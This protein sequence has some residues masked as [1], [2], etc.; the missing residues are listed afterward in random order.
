[1]T[2]EEEWLHAWPYAL[3]A[4]SPFTKLAPPRLCLTAEDE[5][6]EGLTGSFAMIRL[7]DHA[8]VVGLRQVAARGL[9]DYATEILAHEVGHHVYAPADLRD[10]ARLM[11]RVRAGLPSRERDAALVANLY[12]D[13]LINDRLQR[14]A[15][16]DMIGVYRTLKAPSDDPLWQV[17]LRMYEV[18]WSLPSGSL[19]EADLTR[20]QQVDAALGARLVRTHARDWV[21]GA[22]SFAVLCLTYLLERPEGT[23]KVFAPWLDAAGAGAGDLVPDGLADLDDDELSP[24]HPALDPATGGASGGGRATVGGMKSDHREPTQYVELMKSLGVKVDEDQLVIRYYRELAVPHLVRFPA[25]LAKQAADPLPEGL[26]VWDVGSPVAQ[27]D[28]VQ[29]LVRS[30]LVVPGYT[31]YERVYG[32]T[33]GGQPK[34]VPVDLYLGVDCSGSMVNP[35]HRLSYPVL[36]GAIVTLS[37][38]RAGARAM[39]CLSGEPGEHTETDGFVRDER[40]V[41]GV[42]T[43]YL[44]TGYSYGVLRLK[45]TFLDGAPPARPTHLLVVTDSDIFHMLGEVAGGWE[46]ARR[47]AEVAGGGA[48]FVLNIPSPAYH[49]KNIDRLRAIG[50]DVHLV[51]TM[52]ELVAF[53]R[54]FSRRHYEAVGE[55]A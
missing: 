46:I 49:A 15:G 19:V 36:A 18:L 42:L 1:M 43:G 4:W 45:E 40:R 51:S 20:E 26:D 8:V 5:A 7:V 39:A 25:R 54:A 22:G 29:S 24:V 9:G 28:W 55:G 38:L 37:A 21:R 53:A 23:R 35:K 11:A 12:T 48:T 17:Y 10:N 14:S 27:I 3:A 50:W 31:T 32:T 6:R 41:L 34:R 16:L 44:G 47:A 13:L 52:P 2:L 33:D 30:P